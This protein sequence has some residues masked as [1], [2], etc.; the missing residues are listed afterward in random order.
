MQE[1]KEA[2]NRCQ[3]PLSGHTFLST[4]SLV[5]PPSLVRQSCYPSLTDSQKPLILSPCRNCLL[6]L[7]LLNCFQ[8]RW[9]LSSNRIRPGAPVHLMSLEG[10]LHHSRSLGI[11]EF[12]LSSTNKRQKGSTTSLRPCSA[13]LQKNP[14]SW[15]TWLSW[16]KYAHSSLTSSA[17]GLSPFEASLGYQ[18][19]LFPTTEIHLVSWVQH[20]LQQSR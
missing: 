16:V 18:P 3:A 9:N 7:S 10:F 13:S 15:S 17:I 12:W 11:L 1:T 6:H 20:H 19:P 2:R 4:L 14:S 8:V 5:Y